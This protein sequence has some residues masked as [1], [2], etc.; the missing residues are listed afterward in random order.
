MYIQLVKMCCRRNSRSPGTQNC[1]FIQSSFMTTVITMTLDVD[2]L[3]MYDIQYL[4]YILKHVS[5]KV[6]KN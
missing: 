3:K 5:S 1:N 4:Y 2:T 6:M